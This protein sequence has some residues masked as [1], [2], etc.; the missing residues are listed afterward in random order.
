MR[1]ISNLQLLQKAKLHNQLA[2]AVLHL[3]GHINS[4]NK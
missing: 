3:K 2:L 1:E 4:V